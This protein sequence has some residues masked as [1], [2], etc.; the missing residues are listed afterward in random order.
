LSS[1]AN[2]QSQ[3]ENPFDQYGEDDLIFNVD[4]FISSIKTN[5]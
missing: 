2:I 4:K 3:L 1:L 5:T